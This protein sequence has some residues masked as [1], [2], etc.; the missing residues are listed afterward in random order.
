MK[1]IIFLLTFALSLVLVSTTSANDI[2]LGSNTIWSWVDNVQIGRTSGS[3]SGNVGRND[4]LMD[5]NDDNKFINVSRGWE[6]GL[7]N[8]LIRFARD[9]K[10]LFYVIATVYFLIIVLKLI[11]SSN[12]EEELGKFKKW[13]LWITIGIIVMQ[14]AFVFTTILF[15][16]WVSASLGARLIQN[17]VYPMIAL[18]QTLASMFFVAM[19]VFAFYRL[20]TANGN[21]DA[22]KSGRMTIAYALIGFL[23]VRLAKLIVEAFYGKINCN[24]FGGG[25]VVSNSQTCVNV[26]DVSEGIQII[27]NVINWLNWFVAIAVVIM[28]IYA[29]TQILLSAGDEEKI[30]KWKQSLIYI[31]IGLLVLVTNFLI[32]TFFLR[33]EAVI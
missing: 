7:Y 22:I 10:N 4:K 15:D 27:I 3:E 5:L 23:I 11:F 2:D 19:A 32:I 30:K 1:K 26:A 21:E 12:T 18:L 29:G 28:I 6:R 16:Q 24:N 25:L 31:A 13:I 17:L 14:I 20:I 9:F 33:P 8:A